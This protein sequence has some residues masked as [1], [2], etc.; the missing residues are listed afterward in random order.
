MQKMFVR[1]WWLVR[2]H[3]LIAVLSG[4]EGKDPDSFEDG[5][6]KMRVRSVMRGRW[7][8]AALVGHGFMTSLL[9]SELSEVG[10]CRERPSGAE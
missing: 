3:F 9:L 2:R 5:Y 8:R 1:S 10:G 4:L 7:A 6:K